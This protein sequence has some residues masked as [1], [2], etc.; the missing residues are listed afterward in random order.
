W[1][2]ANFSPDFMVQVYSVGWVNSH[3]SAASGCGVTEP[4]GKFNRYEY[5]C[6]CTLS[7]PLSYEPAG[8]IETT[9][10]VVP[11]MSGALPAPVPAGPPDDAESPG[12]PAPQADRASEAARPPAIRAQPNL[13]TISRHIL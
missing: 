11:T 1:P 2:L 13:R 6:V 10:S 5:T 9:L 7:E 12:R 8:S 3:F 4:A